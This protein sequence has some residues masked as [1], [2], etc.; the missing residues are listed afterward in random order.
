MK[1]S[2]IAFITHAQDV[3]RKSADCVSNCFYDLNMVVSCNGSTQAALDTMLASRPELDE[4]G[5]KEFWLVDVTDLKNSREKRDYFQQ[6]TL[7]KPVNLIMDPL[8]SGPCK[9]LLPAGMDEN[10]FLYEVLSPVSVRI[11]EVYKIDP[12][13]EAQVL[14]FGHWHLEEGLIVSTDHK[15]IRRADLKVPK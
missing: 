10:I 5:R 6:I 15:W 2:R 12:S 9:R 8:N 11:S 4:G 14:L 1:S 13:G 3:M 7:S